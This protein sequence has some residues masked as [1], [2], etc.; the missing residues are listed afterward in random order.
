MG[1]HVA[2][3]RGI[4]VAGKNRLP[5]KVLGDI[6][7]SVG[8]LR[9][10]AYI[11]SGNIVFLATERLA[12]H[13]PALVSEELARSFELQV[14]VVM[15]TAGQLKRV[16]RANPF[17]RAGVDPQTLHVLFLAELPTRAR[18]STLDAQRSS[19]DQ[20]VVM[21]TEIYL[22]CPNGMGRTKLTNA[23]FDSKLATTTTARNW[24]TV[25]KLV[26]MTKG[27]NSRMS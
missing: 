21:G 10:E 24:R 11:Q 20:F 15:R 17:L 9:V 12:S 3:L 18:V 8:C 2:L 4:N 1:V 6:F 13:V 27:K 7:N 14:P 16:A 26:E 23:Y 22:R 5:M 25:L 19:P